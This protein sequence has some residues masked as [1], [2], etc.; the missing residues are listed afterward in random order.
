MT[1]SVMVA[2]LTFTLFRR[3]N[4]PP[5]FYHCF[6]YLE[7]E[8]LQEQMI[9]TEKLKKKGTNNTVVAKS[10]PLSAGCLKILELYPLASRRLGAV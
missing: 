3:E 5:S 6:K 2:K 7:R 4:F 10:I 1:A 9:L 8:V